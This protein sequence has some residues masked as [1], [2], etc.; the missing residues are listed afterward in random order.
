M[1]AYYPGM[2]E[3]LLLAALLSAENLW[4]RPGPFYIDGEIKSGFSEHIFF[5][6][7]F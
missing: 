3:M 6:F 2:Q 1:Q 7:G 4:A 5:T